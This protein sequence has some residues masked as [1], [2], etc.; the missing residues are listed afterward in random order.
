MRTVNNVLAKIY[1]R[2]KTYK[3]GNLKD[4][5]LQNL[6][7]CP[8]IDQTRRFTYKAAKVIPHYS[9]S[10]W[11]NEY[12]IP[13]TQQFLDMLLNLLPLLDDK[14][15][16]SY[17]VESLFTNIPIKGTVEEIHHRIIIYT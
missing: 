13:D 4:I 5:T 7:W 14:K 17:D 6:K 12:S 15:D 16:V 8:I 11:Q 9:K 2:V 3:L 1:G 10:L